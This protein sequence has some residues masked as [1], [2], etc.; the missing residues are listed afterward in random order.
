MVKPENSFCCYYS[1]MSNLIKS[2]RVP[3]R[4]AILRVWCASPDRIPFGAVVRTRLSQVYNPSYW[5][6]L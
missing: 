5:R 3:A 6:T 2:L 4:V 1:A